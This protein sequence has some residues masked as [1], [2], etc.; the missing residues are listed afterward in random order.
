[1]QL[2]TTPTRSHAHPQNGQYKF[3]Q[4]TEERLLTGGGHLLE[5]FVTRDLSVQT[6]D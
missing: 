5:V 2:K 3:K 1:M 6:Y 4:I